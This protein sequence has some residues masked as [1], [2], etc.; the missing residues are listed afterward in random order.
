MS[1]TADRPLRRSERAFLAEQR[2]GRLATI[3]PRGR[4]HV[5]P[6][7]FA[8]SD[9]RVFISLDEKPK[10]VEA[11][12]LQRVRNLK[13]SPDVALVVDDYS[14][15]WLR[16]GYVMV[17]GTARLVEVDDSGHDEAIRHLR[18]KYPQYE[19]MAIDRLPLIQINLIG[20]ISWSWSGERFP[21]D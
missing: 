17:R 2:V 18:E 9:D 20:A 4:P 7:C 1:P 14:E 8:L 12:R 3:D 6:V 15:D 19:S 13:L 10:T 11:H 5:V 16:L 21:V